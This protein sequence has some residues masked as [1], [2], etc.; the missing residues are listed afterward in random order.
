[1]LMHSTI[2]DPTVGTFAEF[3]GEPIGVRTMD[4][5]ISM[6]GT[7]HITMEDTIIPTPYTARPT[8]CH[9]E[10]RRASTTSD[11]PCA[12]NYCNGAGHPLQLLFNFSTALEEGFVNPLSQVHECFNG[13]S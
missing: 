3:I 7:D 10:G 9:Y 4:I 8:S 11:N 6:E 13:H 12:A 2:M 1:M 5:H